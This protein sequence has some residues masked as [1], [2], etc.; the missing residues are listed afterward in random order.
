M[1]HASRSDSSV[2]DTERAQTDEEHAP[3]LAQVYRQLPGLAAACGANPAALATYAA[4]AACSGPDAT[5]QRHGWPTSLACALMRITHAVVGLHPALRSAFRQA[6][7][8]EGCRLALW[9]DTSIAAA[10]GYYPSGHLALAPCWLCLA[11]WRVRQL[12]ALAV[13]TRASI[14]LEGLQDAIKVAADVGAN[15]FGTSGG[16][17]SRHLQPLTTYA[18]PLTEQAALVHHLLLC[19]ASDAAASETR[20]RA[21][22]SCCK[23]SQGSAQEGAS[24]GASG[25]LSTEAACASPANSEAAQTT[26]MSSVAGLGLCVLLPVLGPLLADYCSGKV[27]VQCF[28][29]RGRLSMAWDGACTEAPWRS[30][31]LAQWLWA[32]LQVDAD[33]SFGPASEQVEGLV[34]W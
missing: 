6:L 12:A 18:L 27:D 15:R 31:H 14:A 8:A 34:L 30:T 9:Q 32:Q 20:T 13:L 3:C 7:I 17:C 21:S 16:M 28:P 2:C 24:K 10:A 4:C 25:G 22:G 29:E 33:P 19:P 23:Q 26:D 5:G 1:F 11:G